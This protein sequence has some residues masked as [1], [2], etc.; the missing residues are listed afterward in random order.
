MIWQSGDICILQ[1]TGLRARITRWI[2]EDM[3]MVIPEH[4]HSEI[5]VHI[6]DILPPGQEVEADP[7]PPSALPQASGGLFPAGRGLYVAIAVDPQDHLLR[8]ARLFLANDSAEP[9]S[10]AIT[11]QHPSA[12]DQAAEGRLPPHTWCSLSQLPLDQLND[13]PVLR[14][15][16]WKQGPIKQEALPPFSLKIRAAQVITRQQLPDSLPFEAALLPLPSPEGNPPPAIP[17]KVRKASGEGQAL[18]RLV[19]TPDPLERAQFSKELDLHAEK[20]FPNPSKV[21]EAAIYARQ[22]QVFEAYLQKAVRLGVPK[23]YVI[24]GLGK[25]RLRNAILQ[26]SLAHPHVVHAQNVHHPRYGF[27]ATEIILED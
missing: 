2:G 19:A 6:E 10:F 7:N 26:K 15:Q 1:H 17:L 27:G 4:D 25:G 3:V 20:L 12:K 14:G 11:L 5:P 13:A 22:I 8:M 18:R 21:S 23:V 24:H 16:C 9:I